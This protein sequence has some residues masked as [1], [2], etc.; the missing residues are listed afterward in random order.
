M[1]LSKE[2]LA[3]A[4]EAKSIEELIA[5]A[6]EN[7]IELTV[8]KAKEYFAKL[9]AKNEELSDEELDNVSG[10]GCKSS[11]TINGVTFTDDEI[12]NG[13]EDL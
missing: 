2:L 6:K 7:G 5:L 12:L 3:K 4:K 9:N 13:G 11:Y 10:G 1:E 8:E